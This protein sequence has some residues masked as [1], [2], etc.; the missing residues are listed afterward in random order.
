MKIIFFFFFAFVTFKNAHNLQ[1]NR[2]LFLS[3]A[4]ASHKLSIPMNTEI[5]LRVCT[6]SILKNDFILLV[7]LLPK[8]YT[9]LIEEETVI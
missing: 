3:I 1:G 6:Y 2:S 8:H 4:N 7:I 9:K 5:E